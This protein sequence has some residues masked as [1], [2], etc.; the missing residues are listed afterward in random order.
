MFSD[1][2]KALMLVFGGHGLREAFQFLHDSNLDRGPAIYTRFDELDLISRSQ[3][4]QNHKLQIVFR[5]L[6]TAVNG[7]WYMVA[8]QIKKIKHSMCYV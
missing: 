5:F 1:S 2:T 6:C 8:T 4:C 3:L 7:T